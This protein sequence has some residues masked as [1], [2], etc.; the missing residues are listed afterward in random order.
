M[1]YS[2]MCSP[3]YAVFVETGEEDNVKERLRY[4]FEDRMRFVVPRRVLNERKDGQ[5]QRRERILFPG[6]VLVNGDISYND[7]Y[8]IKDVPGIYRL[9]RSEYDPVRLDSSEVE[10]LSKLISHSETIDFSN[11]II[12]N[13]HVVVVDGPLKDMEGFI[14]SV[15]HRKGRAKVKFNL[16]GEERYVDIGVSVLRSAT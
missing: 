10:V 5:W 3:W 4:R 8:N 16:L 15:N 13:G 1:P 9:L 12:E 7:Y 11:V 2:S 14:V 6:Y